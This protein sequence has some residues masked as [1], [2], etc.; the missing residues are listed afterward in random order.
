M[1]VHL[2]S[3]ALAHSRTAETVLAGHDGYSLAGIAVGRIRELALGVVRIPLEAAPEHAE[4][5]GPKPKSVRRTLATTC[6]W[7]L[8]RNGRDAVS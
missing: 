7:V 3:V 1:S 6:H 2:E 8:L 4:V 5:L